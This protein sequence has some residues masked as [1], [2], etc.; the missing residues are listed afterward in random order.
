MPV[1]FSA[2][3]TSR[4]AA[5]AL[6]RD[7]SLP[8]SAA[9]RCQKTSPSQSSTK[10]F[11]QSAL[12]VPRPSA[13]R[14]HRRLGQ[15]THKG[16]PPSR[17]R[18]PLFLA[19]TL[20]RDFGRPG[21]TSLG[22]QG[23]LVARD[24]LAGCPRDFRRDFRWPWSMSQRVFSRP[25]ATNRGLVPRT[26]SRPKASDRGLISGDF[27]RLGPRTFQSPWGRAGFLAR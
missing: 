14:E 22:S 5:L 23:L 16:C 11:R 12:D 21:T 4:S 25:G 26:P 6:R 20:V 3:P 15:A 13:R 17:E 8:S 27:S 24:N 9:P 18:S 10:S 1:R 7:R 2:A 19:G